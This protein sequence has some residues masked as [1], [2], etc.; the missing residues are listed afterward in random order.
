MLWKGLKQEVEELKKEVET[1]KK[2][3]KNHRHEPD[4]GL[5]YSLYE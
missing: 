2:V 3:M 4:K 5:V 1:L